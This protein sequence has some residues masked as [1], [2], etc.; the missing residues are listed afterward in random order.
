MENNGMVPLNQ[1]I[2]GRIRF[3][4]TR[5][6]MSQD[7]LAARIF[8]SKSTLSKYESGQIPMDT[9]TLYQIAA[10]LEVEMSALVDYPI[11]NKAQVP[12][13]RDPFDN[14]DRIYMY[15][16]DGRSNRTTKTLICLEQSQRSGNTLP[17]RCYMDVSSFDQHEQCKYYYTGTAVQYEMISYIHLYNQFNPTEHITISI[18]NPFHRTQHIWGIMSAISFNPITPFAIKC[19]LSPVQMPDVMLNKEMLTLNKDDI[20]TIKKLNMLLLNTDAP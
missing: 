8:K 1:H 20:K 14:A 10:A 17:C 16:F 5:R 11:P 7:Q 4:R 15:Y 3:F 2:G 18:L 13:Y 12:L 19:L 6:N 9:D